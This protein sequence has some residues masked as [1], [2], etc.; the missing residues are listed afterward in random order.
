MFTDAWPWVG[1]RRMPMRA[2]RSKHYGT[3]SFRSFL[4]VSATR[5]LGYEEGFLKLWS[6]LV[7]SKAEETRAAAIA[8]VS[9]WGYRS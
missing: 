1:G 8:E 7:V 5:C 2:R 6:A 4:T 3:S 9:G